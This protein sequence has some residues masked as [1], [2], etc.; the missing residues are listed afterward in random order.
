MPKIEEIIKYMRLNPGGVRFSDLCKAC[1]HYFGEPRQKR[2]SHRIF[3]TPWQGD[4]MVNIQNTKEKAKAYQV[5]QVLRAV[6][7]LVNEK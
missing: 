2:M 6:E 3:K 7:R 4:S 5:R 1:E